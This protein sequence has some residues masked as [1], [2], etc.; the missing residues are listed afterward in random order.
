MRRMSR[1]KAESAEKNYRRSLQLVTDVRR[2]A[3]G[4]LAFLQRAMPWAGEP[5][6][7]VY[8]TSVHSSKDGVVPPCSPPERQHA[9]ELLGKLDGLQFSIEDTESNARYTVFIVK[10]TLPA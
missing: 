10:E 9:Q 8:A 5:I 2:D 1:R 3:R 6:S 4:Y 7:H